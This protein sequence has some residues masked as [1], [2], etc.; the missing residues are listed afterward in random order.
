MQRLC[1]VEM[2][3]DISAEE[4]QAPEIGLRQVY[5][6]LLDALDTATGAE[7]ASA[8]LVLDALSVSI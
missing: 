5:C 7:E 1:W 3:P 6:A 4:L 8:T 2:E